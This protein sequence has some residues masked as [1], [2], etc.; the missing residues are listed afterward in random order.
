[1]VFFGLNPSFSSHITYV[2]NYGEHQLRPIPHLS[3]HPYNSTVKESLL[4][5]IN[6]QH[7]S[8]RT[9]PTHFSSHSKGVAK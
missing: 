6:F 4:P 8:Y 3:P 1:M 9:T 5:V 7:Y 2:F